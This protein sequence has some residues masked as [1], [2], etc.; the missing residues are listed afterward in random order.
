MVSY[1]SVY[2]YIFIAYTMLM[3]GG[4]FN[5][6][7]LQVLGCIMILGK[8]A[9]SPL[10]KAMP[11]L[12]AMI[13]NSQAFTISVV[14]SNFLGLSFM[15]I[16][17]NIIGLKKGRS[18][19]FGAFTFI[20]AI[21]LLSLSFI[22]MTN[23]NY[24]DFA[25]ICQMLFVLI[26]W[27][28]L[29]GTIKLQD[30]LNIITYFRYGCLLMLCGM[31]VQYP[32]QT[33]EIGRFHAVLDDCNY[34]G[35]VSCVLLGI[36]LL[37]YC[38]KLPLRNNRFYMILAILIGLMS[39][40]RGFMLS[41]AVLLAILLL[42]YSFKGRTAKIV[43]VFL[44]LL[45][46]FY[47]LYLLGFGPAV[48]VYDNTIG[49]TMNLNESHQDGDFMDVTSGRTLLWAYYL[50][51][52]SA[53]SSLFYFGRGFYNYFTIKNGGYGLAAHNMVVSSIVGVG[54]IGTIIMLIMYL[55]FYLR[56]VKKTQIKYKIS[57]GSIIVAVLVCYFFLDGI[58]ETRL[59]SYFAIATLLF[60][61]WNDKKMIEKFN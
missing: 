57:F 9:V 48:T 50:D 2:I 56:N 36:A 11:Y 41:S 12:M 30:A 52:A 47:L 38:Y 32:F 54:V 49:R 46:A 33:T 25:L 4:V 16:L 21:Y 60:K 7:A 59:I 61:I 27:T 31:I 24:Y 19:S 42:T 43:L 5:I 53:D 39:G 3:L 13:P 34:T 58:L 17:L 51:R 45:F 18:V 29:L 28:N 22:R 26:A 6:V 10:N 35:G 40:S 20:G 23:G 14:G 1:K 37:T 55:A 8:I 15:F 44:L